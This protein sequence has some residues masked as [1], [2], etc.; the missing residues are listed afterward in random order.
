VGGQGRMEVG[1]GEL[2]A[3]GPQPEAPGCLHKVKLIL[4]RSKLPSVR[5]LTAACRLS[6]IHK[7]RLPK[8]AVIP[9]A[10]IPYNEATPL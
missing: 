8:L 9:S 4:V 3:R 5:M 6:C 7:Q 10:S 2:H 1:G